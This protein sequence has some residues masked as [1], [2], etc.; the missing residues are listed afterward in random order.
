M[1]MAV[2]DWQSAFTTATIAMANTISCHRTYPE[3]NQQQPRQVCSMMEQQ[4]VG[5]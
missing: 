3:V 4:Q 1:S 2:K 5:G